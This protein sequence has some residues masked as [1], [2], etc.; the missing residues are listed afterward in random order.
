[1]FNLKVIEMNYP[2]RLIKKG[3]TNKAII[4]AIQ[5]KLN[6]KGYGPLDVSVGVFGPKTVS[7]V[8]LFQA[9]NTDQ[10]GDLLRPDGVVGAITWAVLFGETTVP[11][12]T[13]VPKSSLRKLLK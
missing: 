10:N 13:N 11:F 1:M 4:K 3:E 2:G 8:K 5:N 9:Q 7:A 6:D 12:V